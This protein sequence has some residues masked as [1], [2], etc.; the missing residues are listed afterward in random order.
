MIKAVIID[1]ESNGVRSLELLVDTYCTDVKV[2]GTSTD[3]G[4]GVELVNAFRPDLVFLDICMPGMTG[5]EMLEKISHRDFELIFTTAHKQYALNAIKQNAIDYLLKPIDGRELNKAI[6]RL[7]L[8]MLES[9][10]QSSV[11]EI[12]EKI[13]FL[14]KLKIHLPTKEGIEYVR[15]EDIVYVQAESNHTKI[16]LVSGNIL[17]ALNSLKDYEEILCNKNLSFLRVHKSYI[18]NMAYVTRYVREELGTVV[19]KG[20]KI[21][22]SRSHKDDFLRRIH[23]Q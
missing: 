5:F 14:K 2:V 13:I 11:F 7:K 1:D 18:I 16:M 4:Q 3:P 12:L 6:D 17:N 19:V 15:P 20:T 21:P 9:R 10:A 23:I 8:R 22:V